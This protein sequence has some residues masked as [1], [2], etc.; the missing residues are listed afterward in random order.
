MQIISK[1]PSGLLKALT[2]EAVKSFSPSAFKREKI[3]NANE[4]GYGH[5]HNVLTVNISAVS[6]FSNFVIHYTAY[7]LFKANVAKGNVQR[8]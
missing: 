7:S 8:F 1:N 4:R 2:A 5:T 3:A 6:C